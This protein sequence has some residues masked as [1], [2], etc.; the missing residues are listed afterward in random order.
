MKLR[1]S[2]ELHFIFNFTPIIIMKQ[3]MVRRELIYELQHVASYSDQRLADRIGVSRPTV[4]SARIEFEND[5]FNY[6]GRDFINFRVQEFFKTIERLKKRLDELE[7]LKS[8]ST[9]KVVKLSHY[10]E[11]RNRLFIYT[12][13]KYEPASINELIKIN[14]LQTRI[15]NQITKIL[16]NNILK[17]ITPPNNKL[18][19]YP[20]E[21]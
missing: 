17:I 14:K 19:Q 5:L 18:K 13:I 7:S 6:L 21:I 4:R 20:Y 2:I 9:E 16:S 11:L 15:E 10:E 3:E 8:Q 1:N 12:D